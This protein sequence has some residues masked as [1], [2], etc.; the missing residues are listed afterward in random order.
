[1][2]AAD[3]LVRKSAGWDL[4]TGLQAETNGL[5]MVFGSE[6]ALTGMTSRRPEFQGK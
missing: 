5:S 3:E 6:D 2:Q 1:L 4:T